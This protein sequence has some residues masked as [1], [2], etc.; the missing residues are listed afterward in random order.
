MSELQTF[1]DV[2]KDLPTATEPPVE[3]GGHR[4]YI[5]DALQYSEQTHTFE[6]VQDAVRAGSMQF[7]PGYSSAVVTEIHVYPKAK[8]LHI[9]LAGGNLEEIEIMAPSIL[10]WGY[11][12]GCEAASI[13]GRRGWERSFLTKTGWQKLNLIYLTKRLGA[14][15]YGNGRE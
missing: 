9:F 5:E 14:E 10:K 1:V 4:A 2:M 3:M 15:E 8:C 7:W 11:V 12:M 13:A 6:D